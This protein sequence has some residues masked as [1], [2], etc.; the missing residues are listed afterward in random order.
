MRLIQETDR[1]YL[2]MTKD[3]D[4]MIAIKYYSK[5]TEMKDRSLC[6]MCA[7]YDKLY[8]LCPELGHKGL[9]S[10]CFRSYRQRSKWYQEDLHFS[11]NTLVQFVLQYGLT[12]DDEDLDLIQEFMDDHAHRG[13]SIRKFIRDNRG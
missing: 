3:K 9:C 6:D 7:T 12:F 1:V 11:M 8:Y 2:Y 10:A 5:E 4:K 13:L